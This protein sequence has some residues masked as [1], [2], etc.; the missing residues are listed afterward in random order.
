MAQA[1][2]YSTGQKYVDKL[3]TNKKYKKK[4]IPQPISIRCSPFQS[5]TAVSAATS[6][7]QS[8]CLNLT[9]P[10]TP[11]YGRPDATNIVRIVHKHNDLFCVCCV[12]QRCTQRA[13]VSLVF[14]VRIRARSARETL[15][16]FHHSDHSAAVV[17]GRR[18]LCV[19]P[20]V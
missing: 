3:K 18:A 13:H 2:L 20:L 16:C 4:I 1:E 7:T 15:A 19:A 17:P 6:D 11:R 12:A 5:T 9:A 14:C 10:S 8:K